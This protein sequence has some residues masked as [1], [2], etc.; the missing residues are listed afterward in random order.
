MRRHRSRNWALPCLTGSF[1]SLFLFWMPLLE[2]GLSISEGP[3]WAIFIHFYFTLVALQ[4]Y[5]KVTQ[6][7]VWAR[8][9]S[10][11]LHTANPADLSMR[12]NLLHSQHQTC[13]KHLLAGLGSREAVSLYTL[14]EDLVVERASD[15]V[16]LLHPSIQPQL[17]SFQVLCGVSDGAATGQSPHSPTS[18]DGTRLR[19]SV[20]STEV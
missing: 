16:P 17:L 9:N 19:L 10:R 8:N 14:A 3:S 2:D 13:R 1:L 15:C 5:L 18:K 20:H 7:I 4:P 11:G 12:V 6:T